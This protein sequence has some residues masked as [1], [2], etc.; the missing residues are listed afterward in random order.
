MKWIHSL[1]HWHRVDAELKEE[2]AQHLEEKVEAL[3]E[4]GIT[5]P[6]ARARAHREFGNATH[7]VEESRDQWGFAWLD[8]I[9]QDLRY[10]LRTLRRSPVLTGVAALSLALGIGA[11][12]AIFSLIDAILLRTLP[13]R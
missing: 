5:A 8:D 1:R 6:E 13:V 7:F 12:T 11:N 9:R 4:A 2:M 3:M 10:G